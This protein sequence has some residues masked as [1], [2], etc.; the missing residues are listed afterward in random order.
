MRKVKEGGLFICYLNETWV[1]CHNIETKHWLDNAGICF[2][3][4]RKN[5][6]NLIVQ[7]D[8]HFAVARLPIFSPNCTKHSVIFLVELHQ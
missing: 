8:F 6:R 2:K 5:I 7:Y 1:N 4:I 3:L